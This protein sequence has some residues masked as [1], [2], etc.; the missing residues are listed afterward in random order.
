MYF[1][2]VMAP[3]KMRWVFTFRMF[4]YFWYPSVFSWIMLQDGE[5]TCIR[6]RC[7]RAACARRRRG[8]ACCA[9]ARHR[10][11][12]AP[13]P[14]PPSWVFLSHLSPR[15]TPHRNPRPRTRQWTRIYR[16]ILVFE[17]RMSQPRLLPTGIIIGII[18]ERFG[19]RGHSAILWCK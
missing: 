9:C 17:L 14:P 12:R 7:S 18:Q 5:V 8:D 16:L 11:Q 1:L 6:K 3:M 13:P 4:H 15:H 19:L 2:E 10:R